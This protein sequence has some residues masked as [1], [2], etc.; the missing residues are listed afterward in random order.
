MW[1]LAVVQGPYAT[2]YDGGKADRKTYVDFAGAVNALLQDG[3][4]PFSTDG[5][6]SIMVWFRK[7][8]PVSG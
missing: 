2:V 4:E 8:E 1:K 5:G 7:R 3:W 6:T